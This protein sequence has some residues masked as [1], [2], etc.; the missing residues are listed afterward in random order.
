MSGYLKIPLL[1][2]CILSGVSLHSQIPDQIQR[3]LDRQV[4]SWNTGDIEDFMGGY[5]QSESLSFIGA[6]G[7]TKGWHN[8]L[9]RYKNAYPT[10]EKMGKLEFNIIEGKNLGDMYYLVHG[11]YILKYPSSESTGFFSL[12]FEK[13]DMT[14]HII[15]DHSS[16]SQR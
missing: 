9:Q 12:V 14:W 11:E 2:Y 3:V 4:K 5:K 1:L 13:T 8:T 7:M 16:A 10:K 15:S 6:N